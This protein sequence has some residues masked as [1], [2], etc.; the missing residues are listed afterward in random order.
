MEH[1]NANFDSGI[2]LTQDW[3][4]SYLSLL[5]K[6]DIE[7]FSHLWNGEYYSCDEV[8]LLACANLKTISRNVQEKCVPY[9]PIVEDVSF[10]DERLSKAVNSI[11]KE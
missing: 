6:D 1:L 3:D 8:L 9:A 2:S 7:D 5:F 4:P 11:E 10:D